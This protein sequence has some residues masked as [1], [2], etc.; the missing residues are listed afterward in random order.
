[1]VQ[2]CRNFYVH[3]VNTDSYMLL[4]FEVLVNP[5]LRLLGR[6]IKTIILFSPLKTKPAFAKAKN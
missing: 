6:L 2:A 5:Y 3:V 4:I 1:M